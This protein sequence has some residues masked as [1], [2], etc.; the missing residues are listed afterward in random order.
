MPKV[1]VSDRNVNDPKTDQDPLNQEF[2]DFDSMPFLR[3]LFMGTNPQG[4]HFICNGVPVIVSAHERA[5]ATVNTGLKDVAKGR[6]V[7]VQYL[8]WEGEQET[9]HGKYEVIDI[10]ATA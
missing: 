8:G 3:G 9:G 1:I 4:H 2:H 7:S 10:E 5:M 6:L